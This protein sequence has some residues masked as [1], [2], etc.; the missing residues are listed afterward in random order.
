MTTLYSAGVTYAHSLIDG[1]KVD[2]DSPWAFTAEDGKALLGAGGGDWASFGR[3]HMGVDAAAAENTE[4][5]FKYPFAK[6]GKLYRSALVAIRD[7]A[8]QQ[9]DN[10]IYNAAGRLLDEIDGKTSTRELPTAPGEIERRGFVAN[11]L[12]VERNGKAATLS[13][14]A[15]VFGALSEDLGGFREQ[16][17]PG[18]FADVIKNKDDV[19]ALFNHDTNFVIGRTTSGTL[20]LAED[21]RG[22]AFSIDLPPNKT[23][24]DLV[25]APIERG[26]IS[27]MSF[28]FRAID[29]AWGKGGGGVVRTLKKVRLLDVSPVTFPAYPQTDVAVREL[30]TFL[31]TPDPQSLPGTLQNLTRARDMLART[32]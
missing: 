16:I 15:A 26:D 8:A 9:G 4:G 31:A 14:H 2:K 29:Q 19:R 21:T 5:R 32:S 10:A 25:V 23:V 30:R 28:Q 12:R 3:A 17:A 6:D 13:G 1:G 22:L 7:R 27:Q 24:R 11:I 20:R 18:A